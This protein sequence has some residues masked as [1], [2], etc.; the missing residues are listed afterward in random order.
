MT[1][2]PITLSHQELN[3]LSIVESVAAKHITQSQ[4]ATQ[5]QRSTRQVKRLVR[6]YRPL[7][8]VGLQFKH[9]GQRPNNAISG[10]H[11]IRLT[12]TEHQLQQ[13]N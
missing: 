5:L 13:L 11:E 2:E 4:A 8:T 9:R 12:L 10:G 7:G 6:T 1:K 3:R